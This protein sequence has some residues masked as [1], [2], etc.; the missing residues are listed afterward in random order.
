MATVRPQ[1]AILQPAASNH[2][3]S[4]V[5]DFPT[6][7]IAMITTSCSQSTGGDGSDGEATV[8]IA[9]GLAFNRHCNA[10]S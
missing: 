10:R 9:A 7:G 4:A 5:A 3:W 1:S 2:T 6:H 8:A